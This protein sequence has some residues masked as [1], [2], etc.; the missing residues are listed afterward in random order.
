MV[1]YNNE[2]NDHGNDIAESKQYEEIFVSKCTK[3]PGSKKYNAANNDS[4]RD[5]KMTSLLWCNYHYNR[6]PEGDKLMKRQYYNTAALF[7]RE[8]HFLPPMCVTVFYEKTVC[9]N[10]FLYHISNIIYSLRRHEIP[11][12]RF[13]NL[14]SRR[15]GKT[16]LLLT[17][18]P[19]R[20]CKRL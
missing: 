10:M 17:L 9:Y 5:M 13:H 14:T 15:D 7:W 12:S 2:D 8:Y 6:M 19:G 20:K 3:W 18:L 16:H 4:K 1:K 11:E